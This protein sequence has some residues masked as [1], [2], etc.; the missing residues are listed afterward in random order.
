MSGF[1]KIT[2]YQL[3]ICF[4]VLY[5]QPLSLNDSEVHVFTNLAAVTATASDDEDG[6]SSDV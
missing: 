1:I 3:I 5:Q 2:P 4:C 6:K